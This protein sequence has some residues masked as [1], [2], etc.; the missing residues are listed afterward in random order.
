[1]PVS[2]HSLRKHPLKELVLRTSPFI[3]K[4]NSPSGL[5]SIDL[6][7]EFPDAKGFS[8]TNLWYMKKWYLFYYSSACEIADSGKMLLEKE[9]EQKLYQLGGEGISLEKLHQLGGET[10]LPPIFCY[11]PWRHHV[12]IITKCKDI[13]ESLFYIQRTIQEGWSRAGLVNAMEL[14]RQTFFV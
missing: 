7:N 14:T 3:I 12:E 11:V 9:T 1:M 13:N 6:K 8:T 10:P 5:R 4:I 2:L